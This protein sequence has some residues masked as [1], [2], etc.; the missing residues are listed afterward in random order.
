MVLSYIPVLQMQIEVAYPEIYRSR[1]KEISVPALV[2]NFCMTFF[3]HTFLMC[4]LLHASVFNLCCQ[5]GSSANV[6]NVFGKGSYGL[7]LLPDLIF[8]LAL[9]ENV[10]CGHLSRIDWVEQGGLLWV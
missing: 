10:C 4:L 3:P 6:F 7:R 9:L 5:K 8:V 1:R 2:I